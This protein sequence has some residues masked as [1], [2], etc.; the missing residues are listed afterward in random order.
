MTIGVKKSEIYCSL[1]DSCDEFR[2][3]MDASLY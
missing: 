3:G 1:W 2:G